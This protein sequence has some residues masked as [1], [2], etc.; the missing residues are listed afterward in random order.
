[1]PRKWRAMSTIAVVVEAALHDRVDLDRQA[2]GGRGV[3][4]VQHA[5]DG[6][7]DVVHRAERRVV[8]RVEA[9]GHAREPRVGERLRLLRQERAVRR[10]RQLDVERREH[11]DQPLDVPAHE[12]LA[13][14]DAELAHAVRDERAREARDLL[15]VEQLRARQELV[16][17]AE[18]L[19]RHAVDAA[20]VAP[21]GDR[22]AEIAQ[23]AAETIHR[24]AA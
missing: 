22:D 10:Q 8:E 14:G 24:A 16:V 17:A 1:M 20:E 7:V 19:L 18:D 12:R 9:D 13:A 2:G 3:D 23:R 4:A 11:L 5:L 6:E 21:V 15:V